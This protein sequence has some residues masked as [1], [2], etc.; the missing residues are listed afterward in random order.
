[1]EHSLALILLGGC[2][3]AMM[4][5]RKH[6]YTYVALRVKESHNHCPI[7]EQ[8]VNDTSQMGATPYLEASM[9]QLT[10]QDLN[11][12]DKV[13]TLQVQ[14]LIT[15][16]LGLSWVI[17]SLIA[18]PCSPLCL[19]EHPCDYQGKCLGMLLSEQTTS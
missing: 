4:M 16:Y 15:I 5:K 1:M 2:F 17:F 3:P 13:A 10:Y 8:N 12:H 6:A 19:K 11:N 18:I 7:E 14:S 9:S